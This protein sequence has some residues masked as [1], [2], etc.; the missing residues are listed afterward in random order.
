ML[1]SGSM[2][3]PK[4]TVRL[5]R[6]KSPGVP[7]M[8]YGVPG[9]FSRVITL[10]SLMPMIFWPGNIFALIDSMNTFPE[11]SRA[12][13]AIKGAIVGYRLRETSS[14]GSVS[15]G[16]ASLIRPVICSLWRNGRASVPQ[17]GRFDKIVR[18]RKFFFRDE[19]V[20]MNVWAFPSSVF[21]ALEDEMSKFLE[22]CSD[23]AKEEFYL[24]AAVDKWI[25]PVEPTSKAIWLLAN[26]WV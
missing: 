3:F 10:P 6:G 21:P 12:N 19:V 13:E 11:S 7:V 2:I 26:G 25:V 4:V 20:S 18:V 22:N 24:P 16:F 14:H 15:R 23:P 1:T 8:L 17:M 5:L 9:R